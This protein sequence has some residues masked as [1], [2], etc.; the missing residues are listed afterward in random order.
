MF[1]AQRRRLF[2]GP[3]VAFWFGPCFRGLSVGLDLVAVRGANRINRETTR[4][5]GSDRHMFW[6]F[7]Q[8]PG[9]LRAHC[10]LCQ[11]RQRYQR[12]TRRQGGGERL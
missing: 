10:C 11:D 9:Y 6:L 2:W 7:R 3:L 8:H 4:H 12:E 1:C 5:R